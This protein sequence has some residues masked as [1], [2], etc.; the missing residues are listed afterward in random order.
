[1]YDTTAPFRRCPEFLSDYRWLR[2]LAGV[3]AVVAAAC[4]TPSVRA[5]GGA[6]SV[7]EAVE[8]EPT[9][10]GFTSTVTVEVANQSRASRLLKVS[11]AAPF[12]LDGDTVALAAGDTASLVLRFRPTVEGSHSGVLVV[13][14][15]DEV[16]TVPLHGEAL[17]VPSCASSECIAR[18]FEP[19][20]GCVDVV[21]PEGTSCGAA[22]RCLQHA[23]CH[24]GE[25]VG[26]PV[27][28]DDGD[29]CTSDSCAAERGC[30][31]DAVQCEASTDPCQ[32]SACDPVLGCRAVPVVDG[33]SCGENDCQTAHV[34]ISGACVARAS[35]DGSVCAP[36][37]TCH[38]EGRCVS[39]ACSV[40]A[41][42]TPPVAWSY[43]P[44]AG[45]MVSAH[46]L[47]DDGTLF[48]VEGSDGR[49]RPFTVTFAAYEKTGALR[50]E[51]PL[52]ADE[53]SLNLGQAVMLDEATG[54]V[55]VAARTFNPQSVT[56][57]DGVK[58]LVEAF[59]A[60]T[61]TRLWKHEVSA[62]VAL[63]NGAQKF[64]EVRQLLLLDSG[65]VGVHAIEGD[66]LHQTHVLALDGSTGA[67]GFHVQ[68]SGHGTAGVT[69]SGVLFL[70]HTPCWSDQSYT[71]SFD[72]SGHELTTVNEGSFFSAFASDSAV[73]WD[74][75]HY[76]LVG[77]SFSVRAPLP[78]PSGHAFV[79]GGLGWSPTETT[80]VSR[81]AQGLFVNRSVG[82][83]IAW[84]TV[85]TSEL[86][87]WVS[88]QRLDAGRTAAF[89]SGSGAAT[90]ELVVLS[91][92]GQALDR[93]ELPA[94]SA[95]INGG[96]TVATTS[97]GFQIFSTP[98]LDAAATGWIGSGGGPQNT[99]RPR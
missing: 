71:T 24:A 95:E 62:D 69:K 76:E 20:R 96:V 15:D 88:V 29:A 85:L 82:A 79:Y 5:V 68:R 49:Q 72:A 81:S 83:A 50:F 37:T 17:A 27:S 44:P 92:S 23:T 39:G 98:T 25:C 87:K 52:S 63:T 73:R 56:P 28:C 12:E 89:V 14:V 75:T 80:F 11:V 40:P 1:M 4:G 65:A 22:D 41:A 45:R 19:G 55:F 43:S 18:H 90:Q 30:V 7:P 86:S 53:P 54:R 47:A 57:T 94:G 46:A 32:A 31:H 10:T 51:V 67:L 61:G 13:R 48:F 91:S 60:R 26:A 6:L 77:A 42:N 97:S 2:S 66:S 36:A 84:S 74:G 8:F 38:A 33:T 21:Q 35:P 70:G 64:V 16:L 99:N 59:D 93:C 58:A 34:C 3:L 9:F 78:L